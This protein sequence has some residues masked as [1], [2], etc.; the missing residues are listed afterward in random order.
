MHEGDDDDFIL[1]VAA[2]A[3]QAGGGGGGGGCKFSR[4]F[5]GS[6]ST[7][8]H[9]IQDVL[10]SSNAP[11]YPR[12]PHKSRVAR[13][14]PP[15]TLLRAEKGQKADLIGQVKTVKFERFTTLRKSFEE[16][17][18]PGR[19]RGIHVFPWPGLAPLAAVGGTAWLAGEPF[20]GQGCQNATSSRRRQPLA[21]PA[22]ASIEPLYEGPKSASA[23]LAVAHRAVRLRQRAPEHAD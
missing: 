9:N 8:S 14:A 23:G 2:G 13:L 5:E 4:P 11:F 6:N 19:N 22:R 10:R 15:A 21:R 1:V 18:N 3:G 16:E 20:K 17:Q 12:R 7:L